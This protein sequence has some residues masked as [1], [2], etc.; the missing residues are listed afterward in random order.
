MH[1]GLSVPDAG[2]PTRSRGRKGNPPR[3]SA[4]VRYR[5]V[6]SGSIECGQDAGEGFPEN[7]DIVSD[8]GAGRAKRGIAIADDQPGALRR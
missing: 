1:S 6:G 7:R 5:P 8:D 2:A 3:R 4:R